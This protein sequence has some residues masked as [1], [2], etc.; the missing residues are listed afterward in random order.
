LQATKRPDGPGLISNLTD[1]CCGG[2]CYRIGMS[3]RTR[4]LVTSLLPI[5]IAVGLAA[6]L[7]LVS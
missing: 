6:L 4:Q 3:R 5:P 2:A 7:L 1:A